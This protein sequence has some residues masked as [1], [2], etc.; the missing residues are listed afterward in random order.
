MWLVRAAIGFVAALLAIFAVFATAAFFYLSQ[1]E[2]PPEPKPVRN[3]SEYGLEKAVGLYRLPDDMQAILTY[4]ARGGLSMYRL[5]NARF[6]RDDYLS[7]QFIPEHDGTFTWEPWGEAETRTV[8]F[9]GAADNVTGFTWQDSDGQ[10]RAQRLSTAFSQHDLEWQNGNVTLAGTAFIPLR[11][12]E[13]GAVMLHGSGT[14]HRDNLWYLHIA[15]HMVDNGIAVLLPDKRGSGR[16]GGEWRTASFTDFALDGLAGREV[17]AG[18]VD[19]PLGKIGLAGISQGGS[20]VAPIATTMTN[21]LPFVI[22]I[23][24]AA[25]SPNQQLAHETRQTL[26]QH[27]IP[28]FLDFF[29][30]PYA[31]AIPK[32][33]RSIWWDTNGSYDPIPDW[34][35]CWTP[36]LF[37]Y[38]SEDELDNVPVSTSVGRLRPIADAREGFEVLVLEGVGHGLMDPESRELKPDFLNAV[39]DWALYYAA[40]AE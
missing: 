39:T 17:L 37:I 14:S 35:E 32:R 29:V 40:Q 12:A 36:T 13:A 5:E 38:G 30:H 3:Y 34:Q 1:P 27:G 19:L 22:N 4:S 16:S 24:G 2:T 23:S 26:R 21:D 28:E 20:W 8:R 10:H 11:R 6:S 18:L 15:L 9:T 33:R 7:T 25:V 31:V